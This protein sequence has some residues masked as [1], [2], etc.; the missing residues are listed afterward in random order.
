MTTAPAVAARGT[1]VR[2]ST[3][4]W[5]DLGVVSALS[6]IGIIGFETSFGGPSFLAAGIGGLLV[7]TAA[8]VLS[9]LLGLNG[10]VTALAAI[11]AYFIAGTP[12]AVPSQGIAVVLPSLQSLSSLASGSVYGWADILTL[13]TPVG[14]PAYIAVVP[15]VAGWLVGLI[16][17]VLAT[18]WLPSRRRTAG[19]YAIVL[20]GPIVLYLIGILTGTREPY[21]AGIRGVAFAAVAL[22]W[23]GWRHSAVQQAGLASG[24]ALMRQKIAGVAILVVLSVAIGG[25]VGALVAPTAFNRFVLRDEITPPFDP[26]NYPSPLAGFRLYTNTLSAAKLFTVSG[27]KQGDYLRVATMDSYTGKLWNVTGADVAANGSGSFSLVGRDLPTPGIGAPAGTENLTVAVG[28]YSDVW[29]PSDGYPVRIQFE[30]ATAANKDNLRYNSATG[31][32]VVTSGLHPGDRYAVQTELQKSF[33][34]AQLKALPTAQVSMPTVDNVPDIVAAKAIQLAGAATTPYEKLKAIE[35]ALQGGYL[36]HGTAASPSPAGHGA[37]RMKLLLTHTP[38]VGDAEQYASAFALMARS[39]NYPARVVM[40]FKPTVPK[41]TQTL[42]ITGAD[43]TAWVEV[44]FEKVGWVP[45]YP[46]ATNNAI[47]PVVPPQ[48]NAQPLPQVRQPPRV[49]PPQNNVLSPVAIN[50]NK[51]TPAPFEIPGWAYAVAGIVVIPVAL[52]FLPLLVIGAVKRRRRSRRRSRGTGDDRVAGAWDELLD[53]YA[54][55]GYK[56]PRKTTRVQAA[57]TLQGQTPPSSEADRPTM[58]E[59]A[60]ETDEAVF[61]GVEIAEHHVTTAWMAAL[62]E[63]RIATR[64]AKPWRRRLSRFRIRPKREWPVVPGV[65]DAAKLP[66]LVKGIVSR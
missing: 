58:I 49:N 52:Y 55:L 8:G 42:T 22:V 25:G 19:R 66:T 47:P 54:E 3:R 24:R 4:T 17:A 61:S 2:I 37:D 39:L 56:V 7:G 65:T 5:A 64:A 62:S 18:R 16:S 51:K 33:S 32:A 36:S 57:R 40:G 48:T 38:L 11:V 1:T 23:M 12:I 60:A 63:I 31:S 14:A 20:L 13:K 59:F 30:G 50:K 46:T 41:G 28:K 10:V 45:F 35:K 9:Y 27:L 43:V 6:V 53:S 34:A 44:D 29:M 21:L 15:Y 26:L